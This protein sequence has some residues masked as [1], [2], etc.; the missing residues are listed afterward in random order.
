MEKRKC[1][2]EGY[3]LVYL[4]IVFFFIYSCFFESDLENEEQETKYSVGL[5]FFFFLKSSFLS[6]SLPSP[7]SCER[8]R[9]SRLWL[10]EIQV[11]TLLNAKV[12][13]LR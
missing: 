6:L 8:K 4:S 12:G 3:V 13:E 9:T 11:P 7:L 10:A 2:G 5:R 1:L